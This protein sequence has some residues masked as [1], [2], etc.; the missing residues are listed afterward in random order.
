V[1]K[2]GS[3][4]EFL[5]KWR[6]LLYVCQVRPSVKGCALPKLQ[7]CCGLCQS[8]P[9]LPLQLSST[10]VL[11]SLCS[12]SLPEEIHSSE[13]FFKINSCSISFPVLK[14]CAIV[15]RRKMHILLV[16]ILVLHTQG[17]KISCKNKRKLYLAYRQNTNG[18][19]KRH[20][21]LYSRIL[22]NVIREAKTTYCNKKIQKSSNKNKTTWDIIKE[23]T[24]HQHPKIDVQDL[25][26]KNENITDFQEIAEVFN[27]YFTFKK[28]KVNIYKI[29]NRPNNAKRETVVPT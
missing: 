22:E 26:V 10:V 21:R 1:G 28:D 4:A 6:Y 23:V 18:E 20:Y 25:K 11:S 9:W 19:I 17:I 14:I 16:V 3:G 8:L 2:L 24:G 7:A 5:F 29:Q 15:M 12:F 27:D 13:F